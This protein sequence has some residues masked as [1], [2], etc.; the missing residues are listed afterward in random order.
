MNGVFADSY[1]FFAIINPRDERHAEA[2]EY[3]RSFQGRLITTEWVMIEV[4]DGLATLPGRSSFCGLRQ[5]FVD[6]TLNSLIPL[7]MGLYES[8]LDLFQKRP[9]KQWSLT[10]C[11]SFVVMER[12]GL[13]EALTADRHFE[14][15]GFN[16]LFK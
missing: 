10:D 2:K 11:I 1:Y 3:I 4:A 16:A 8:G 7:D 5:K 9:D 6:H 13:K 12:E 15:A 14:Q